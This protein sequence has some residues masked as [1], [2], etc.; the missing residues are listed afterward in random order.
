MLAIVAVWMFIVSILVS[1]TGILLV[2]FGRAMEDNQAWPLPSR[3]V[4]IACIPLMCSVFVLLLIASELVCRS[5]WCA[6]RHIQHS[7]KTFP[8]GTVGTVNLMTDDDLNDG[9]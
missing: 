8:I 4:P 5:A 9:L 7:M 2:A 1:L 3:W 6:H